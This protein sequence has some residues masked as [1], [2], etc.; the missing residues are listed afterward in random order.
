MTLPSGLRKAPKV[1]HLDLATYRRSNS[2]DTPSSASTD[3]AILAVGREYIDQDASRLKY[4]PHS[5]I[6][7]V[8]ELRIIGSGPTKEKWLRGPELGFILGLDWRLSKLDK[9]VLHGFD[10]NSLSREYQARLA[11]LTQLN[12]FEHLTATMVANLP[13][14]FITGSIN[15]RHLE[16]VV[17]QTEFSSQLLQYEEAP[18]VNIGNLKSLRTL[19]IQTDTLE[20]H[21]LRFLIKTLGTIDPRNPP[22]DI[23]IKTLHDRETVDSL[24]ASLEWKVIDAMFARLAKPSHKPACEVTIAGL[25]PTGPPEQVAKWF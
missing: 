13:L 8:R 22:R 17:S 10:W 14:S 12:S 23:T 15:L 3:S 7:N 21:A 18:Q 24:P 5:S 4:D 6:T 16:L 20:V 11:A 9:I 25:L 19:M 2:C 1:I